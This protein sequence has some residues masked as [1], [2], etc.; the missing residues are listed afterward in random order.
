MKELILIILT[1]V[2]IQLLAC[3]GIFFVF[4]FILSKI[5]IYINSQYQRTFGWKGILWTAWIGTPIHELSHA[6]L[7]WLFHHKIHS[8]SIFRP[9]EET[10]GLGHVDHS[11]EKFSLWQRIGN[12]FIGAAP[13]IA[14]PIVLTALLYLFVPHARDIF[15][16]LTETT[17]S[18]LSIGK[19]FLTSL[20]ILFSFDNLHDWQFWLFLYLSFCVSCHMAPSSADLRGMFGGFF[21]V[22]LLLLLVNT[23]AVLADI[24]L[25]AYLPGIYTYL[26]LFVSLFLYAT[27]LS[28]IHLLLV[29]ILFSL[30]RRR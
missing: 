2:G 30:F 5:Q 1:H 3:V 10:G 26:H 24:S 25:N 15:L 29:T 4:G 21:W 27:L 13:M 20:V 22:I 28:L 16:P 8:I 19:G 9:N 6:L 12:F 17:A 7:A 14:G 23:G 11:Y 18:V